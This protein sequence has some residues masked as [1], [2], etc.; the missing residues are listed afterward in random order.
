MIK[1]KNWVEKLKNNKGLPKVVKITGKMSKRWGTGSVAIPA[2]MEVN[3]I[4]KKV[5]KG[6]LISIN[7]I[8]QVI[9]K[10]HKA[11]IGCPITCGI[12]AWIAAN[13]AEEERKQGKKDITPY[14]RTLKS[15]GSLN[16]KY[17]SGLEG[18]KKLLEKEGHKIIRKGKKYLV[19]DY[20]KAFK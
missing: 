16:E 1:Q 15:D 11:T 5:P 20:E 7:Q 17:P 19:V 14:W 10:R 3:E 6:K 13:A 12:F 8:R 4:M 18:Q 9:A 2:P